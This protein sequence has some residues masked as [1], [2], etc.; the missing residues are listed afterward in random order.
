MVSPHLPLPL[1]Q[2]ATSHRSSDSV[3]HADPPAHATPTDT[4]KGHTGH[5]AEAEPQAVPEAE[6]KSEPEVSHP[7]PEPNM[8]SLETFHT[9]DKL[10]LL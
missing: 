10:T 5:H 9:D 1:P 2:P 4:P 8:V 3:V 7:E 6:P